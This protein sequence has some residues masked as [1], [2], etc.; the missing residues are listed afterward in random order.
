MSLFDWYQPAA[1]LIC[2]VC[3]NLLKVWQSKDGPCGLFLWREGVKH[4]VDQ[5]VYDEE[6]RWSPDEWCQFTLPTQ[7]EIY[8]YDCPDHQP[9]D[10]LCR[11]QDGV[12]S[13]T[14]MD[15]KATRAYRRPNL[16]R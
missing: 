13:S 15:L 10:A 8:S 2:P 4:P 3:G 5:L 9:I 11:T 1:E 7:F 12:W 14:T 6:A 16:R